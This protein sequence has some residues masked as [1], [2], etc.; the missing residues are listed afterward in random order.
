MQTITVEVPRSTAHPTTNLRVKHSQGESATEVDVT[1][2]HPQHMPR[3]IEIELPEGVDAHEVEVTG[4][5]FDG[6]GQRD[7][8]VD[9]VQ[10]SVIE[11][12]SKAPEAPKAPEDTPPTGEKAP[13]VV[14]APSAPEVA[15][16]VA[17]AAPVVAESPVDQPAADQPAVEA[18]PSKPSRAKKS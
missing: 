6:R 1:T 11:V 14:T 8:G 16:V 2:P 4:E 9:T 15:P 13:E 5:F 7:P 10:V 12:T 18:A 17:D 3:L